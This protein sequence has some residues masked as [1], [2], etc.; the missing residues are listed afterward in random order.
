MSSVAFR[1]CCAAQ[2]LRLQGNLIQLVGTDEPAGS[3]CLLPAIMPPVW[4][5]LYLKVQLEVPYENL[6]LLAGEMMN[7][8]FL[9][10]FLVNDQNGILDSKQELHCVLC[11]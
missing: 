4:S 11:P 7:K 1:K 6:Q 10:L 2:I 3:S 9:L 5:C 8:D